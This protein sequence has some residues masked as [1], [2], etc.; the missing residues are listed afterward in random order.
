MSMQDRIRLFGSFAFVPAPRPARDIV[1]SDGKHY[2]DPGD[3]EAIRITDGWYAKNIVSVHIPQLKGLVGAPESCRVPFHKLAAQMLVDLWQAWDDA[4]LVG[5]V[6]SWAGSWCPRF[7]RGSTSVLS[8]HAFGTA[9][10]INATWNR[11]GSE[12]A[13]LGV[14]GS[15]IELVPVAEQHGFTW[16]GY[17]PRQDGMHFEASKIAEA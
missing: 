1:L 15:V 14:R 11:M 13:P 3:P 16:G 2:H 7:I 8:N 9:F 17:F 10:D 12:P 5:R 6:L 4:G